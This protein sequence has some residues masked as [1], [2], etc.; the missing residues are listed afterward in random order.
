MTKNLITRFVNFR[1]EPDYRGGKKSS[2]MLSLYLAG[3]TYI[4]LALFPNQAFAIIHGCTIPPKWDINHITIDV[5]LDGK[6]SQASGP[7]CEAIK[8]AETMIA[9]SG[10]S[11]KKK[12][13]ARQTLENLQALVVSKGRDAAGRRVK[14]SAG[15]QGTATTGTSGSSATLTCGFQI[16]F[17]R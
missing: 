10:L 13:G 1:K 12:K 8:Q 16:R 5:V 15:C 2:K 7:F 14:G 9:K 4:G 17:G 3:L 6:N 11:E